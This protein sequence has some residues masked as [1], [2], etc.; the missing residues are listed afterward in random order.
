MNFILS[1]YLHIYTHR[2][3]IYFIIFYLFL[4]YKCS[5]GSA[6]LT[7]LY[8][9]LKYPILL[10][11]DFLSFRLFPLD[12]NV[13]SANFQKY[14]HKLS[15]IPATVFRNCPAFYSSILECEQNLVTCPIHTHQ[16]VLQSITKSLVDQ[17]PKCLGKKKR[18]MEITRN[19]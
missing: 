4:L 9:F 18:W 12:L 2:H 8:S 17:I 5:L 7:L 1:L 6:A 11:T 15:A 10:L 19:I 14:Y 13:V 3:I 16:N